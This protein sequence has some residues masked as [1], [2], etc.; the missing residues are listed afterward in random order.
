MEIRHY[1]AL[2]WR[3]AWL[4]ALG[5]IIAGATTYLV[6]ARTTPVYRTTARLLIDEAPGSTSGNDYS[7]FLLEQRLALTYVEL[8]TTQP[9]LE[10]TIEELD[11]PLT[12]NQL[13]G[14]VT[15]SAL[16]ETQI[17][18]I[19]V[20]HTDPEQAA[21]IANALGT[22][23]IAENQNRESL[24]YAEP[25]QNWEQRIQ[26]LGDEVEAL[27]VK[28]SELGTPERAAGQAA[29]ARLETERNETRIRYTDA[30]NALNRLQLDQARES[31]NVVPIEQA[32]IPRNPIR[33]RTLNN[34]LLAIVA[35]TM[36][37]VGV[38]FLLD[39]LDDTIKTP[40]DI[41]EDTN[42]STLG[43]IALIK[44]NELH[45]RLVTQMRP[46]DPISE[47]F[48]VLRTNLNFSAVDGGLKS[49]LIS[50]SSP[51][52]GKSTTA[53]NLA[54]TMAQTGKN[55]IIIDADLRRPTQHKIFKASNN[56]GLTTAILDSETPLEFHLQ[57]TK[58]PGVSIM[59]SGPLP[60]NPAE[61]L[62]SQRMSHLLENLANEADILIFDTPPALTVADASILAP[63]VD[64]CLLVAN[65]AQTKRDTFIRAVERLQASGATLF[66]AVINRLQLGQSVY[67]NAYYYHYYSSYD[68]NAKP[69]RASTTTTL[70]NLPSKLLAALNRR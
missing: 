1:I 3:W 17:I 37:A 42:L 50:S 11:L 36:A 43:A 66:G 53:A 40:D 5:A 63:Q 61:L 52:E 13:R 18:N 20:E 68:Y 35:G 26:E 29:L 44:G 45:E 33:P 41:L 12:V 9:I 22:V 51:G 7:Q 60:P 2:L 31:S 38:V 58:V 6:S 23:F 32:T 28:I 34:T 19:S 10:K 8:M 39:Y 62:N 14:S 27:D 46:R 48:R 25:I 64:G 67:G 49:V 21:A 59:T 15:V 69:G 24:R 54:V 4:I 55:V 47:A 65:M 56:K 57:T 16:Q 70:R 30:F